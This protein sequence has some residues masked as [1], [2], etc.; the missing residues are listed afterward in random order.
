MNVNDGQWH[1]VMGTYDGAQVCIYVDGIED[2]CVETE[3]AQM[4]LN[5]SPVTFGV[6]YQTDD[7]QAFGGIMDEM[8]IHSIGLP[9]A[10]DAPEAAP[11]DGNNARSVLSIYRTSGG[12]V[13]CADE[14]GEGYF[15]GDV[16]EDC[17]VDLQD[18]K[19]MA[20]IWLDCNDIGN[21]NCIE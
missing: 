6:N 18:I 10:S 1:H 9:H 19:A 5:A 21:E 2:S 14:T 20:Q 17:Y 7:P 4:A 8:R 12:H 15:A 13:S 3:G 16:N 11:L